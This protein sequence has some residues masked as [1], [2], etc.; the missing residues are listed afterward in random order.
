MKLEAKLA[1]ARAE[2]SFM[3]EEKPVEAPRAKA[4]GD[5]PG[6]RVATCARSRAPPELTRYLPSDIPTLY[7][8]WEPR[9]NRCYAEF[10]NLEGYQRTRSKKFDKDGSLRS[11]VIALIDIFEY[12]HQV[13]HLKFQGLSS[14]NPD[15]KPPL[16]LFLEWVC[17]VFLRLWYPKEKILFKVMI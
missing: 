13:H 4:A 12:I 3:P 17:G 10:K 11:K 8:H 16:G 15:W 1:A 6:A 9:Q 5:A 14:Y 2:R 7:L